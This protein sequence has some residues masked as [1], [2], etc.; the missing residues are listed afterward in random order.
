M[1][2]VEDRTRRWRSVVA[3]VAVPALLL[4]AVLLLLPGDDE[5]YVIEVPLGTL[6]QIAAGEDVELMPTDLELAVGDTLE[7][8]NL[9]IATHEVGPYLVGAGQTMRQTFTSPGVIEGVCTLNPSGQVRIT[10]R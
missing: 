9:D 6:A 8:R 7:I 3:L 5:P 4:V 1:S 2:E 10:I